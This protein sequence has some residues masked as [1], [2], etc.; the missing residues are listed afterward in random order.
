MAMSKRNPKNNSTEKNRAR[1]KP[2]KTG[3]VTHDQISERA[4]YLWHEQGR[5]HGRDLDHWLLAERELSGK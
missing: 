1:N 4:Y 2:G 3:M 5:H